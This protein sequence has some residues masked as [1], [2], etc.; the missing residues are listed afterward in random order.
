MSDSISRADLRSFQRLIQ[1][2]RKSEYLRFRVSLCGVISFG[3][4]AAFTATAAG[5]RT[6]IGVITVLAVLM[7]LTHYHD[8]SV[9]ARAIKRA[10]H[11]HEGTR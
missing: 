11:H 7:I 1:I 10:L 5:H 3:V 6:I 9:D 8:A 2:Y 4:A